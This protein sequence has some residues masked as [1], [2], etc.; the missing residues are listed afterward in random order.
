[1]K[2]FVFLT[3]VVH[4]LTPTRVYLAQEKGVAFRLVPV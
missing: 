1:M 4:I 2:Y 3:S